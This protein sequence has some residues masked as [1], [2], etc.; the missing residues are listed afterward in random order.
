[1]SRNFVLP[2][3]TD[4]DIYQVVK[5]AQA[6]AKL[7][8]EEISMAELFNKHLFNNVKIPGVDG[9]RENDAEQCEDDDCEEYTHEKKSSEQS[10]CI[11]TLLHKSK[12]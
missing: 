6:Q 9:G 8:I 5:K 3:I 10:S 7:T 1:M 12:R 11:A 2:S 4:D